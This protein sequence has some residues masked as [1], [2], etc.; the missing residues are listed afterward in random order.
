MNAPLSDLDFAKVMPPYQAYQEIR[1]F[2]GNMAQPEKPIPQIDDETMVE[3]KGHG[4]KYS[5]RK[6]PQK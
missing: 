5:F 6:P 3:I 4:G 2:L 1:M